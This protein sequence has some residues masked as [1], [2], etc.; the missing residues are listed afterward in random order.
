MEVSDSN[1]VVIDGLEGSQYDDIIADPE[2]GS[3]IFDSPNQLH[4]MARKGNAF[5]LVEK[6][7]A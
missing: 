6:H 3:V 2:R 4:Y 1:M 7:W 5:Y